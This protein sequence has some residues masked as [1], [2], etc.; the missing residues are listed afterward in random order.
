MKCSGLRLATAMSSHVLLSGTVL[1]QICTG[2]A[3]TLTC[4]SSDDI[5]THQYGHEGWQH[6]GNNTCTT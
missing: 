1:A 3:R 2:L 5:P 4:S 6:S